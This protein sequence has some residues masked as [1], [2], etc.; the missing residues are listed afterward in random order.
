MVYIN[1]RHFIV[2]MS[3]FKWSHRNALCW[4][5]ERS[6]FNNRT[7]KPAALTTCFHMT[8]YHTTTLLGLMGPI[9]CVIKDHCLD[10]RLTWT[11]PIKEW[12]S[13]PPPALSSRFHGKINLP[14]LASASLEYVLIETTIVFSVKMWEVISQDMFCSPTLCLVCG[15]LDVVMWPGQAPG[16]SAD[17]LHQSNEEKPEWKEAVDQSLLSPST[18]PYSL[19]V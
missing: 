7:N 4:N 9:T 15:G 5:H 3:N 14:L 19:W 1:D 6:E 12:T 18:F 10:W 2:S 13:R 17:T 8:Q 16:K 11:S